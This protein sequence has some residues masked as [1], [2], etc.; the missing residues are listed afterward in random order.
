[1]G[2][3][4]V[5]VEVRNGDI[6]KALK[7]FKRKVEASGHLLELRERKE[8]TKPTTKRRLIKQ[9]ALRKNKLEVEI[10]RERNRY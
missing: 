7:V 9:K 8:Y 2:L 6:G 5:S 4:R 10:E 3:S 1:M